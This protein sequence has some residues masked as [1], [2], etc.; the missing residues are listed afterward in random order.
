MTIHERL[1]E[2][3]MTEIEEARSWSRRVI[4]KFETLIR[5]LTICR[6]T[7][8]TP[9]LSRADRRHRGA[10][11]HRPVSPC[12]QAGLFTMSWDVVCPQSGMVLDS[13][14][15]LRTLKIHYFCGSAT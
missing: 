14:G 10:G 12:D 2:S 3:K 7:G 1:L 4:S 8:S 13:F 11:G 6:F 15:A 9:W 5:T